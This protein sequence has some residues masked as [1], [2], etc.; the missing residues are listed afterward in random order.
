[1]QLHILSRSCCL[2]TIVQMKF[3]PRLNSLHFEFTRYTNLHDHMFT[4]AF[5]YSSLGGN[6]RSRIF[7]RLTIWQTI[8]RQMIA[9]FIAMDTSQS[10][11]VCMCVCVNSCLCEKVYKDVACS[12]SLSSKC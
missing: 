2:V 1:M 3:T 12:V 6:V 11:G 8:W 4:S 10:P 7:Q 9:S 5:W